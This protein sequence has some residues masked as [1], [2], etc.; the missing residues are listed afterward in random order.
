MLNMLAQLSLAPASRVRNFILSMPKDC[1][2]IPISIESMSSLKHVP[3]RLSSGPIQYC[4][5]DQNSPESLALTS[6]RAPKTL[7][8]GT[9]WRSRRGSRVKKYIR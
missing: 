7:V 5:V 4:V 8:D 9:V 6:V 2:L 3:P 1:L